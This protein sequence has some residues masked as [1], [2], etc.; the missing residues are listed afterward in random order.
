MTVTERDTGGAADVETEHGDATLG[1][2]DTDESI[3]WVLVNLGG[4]IEL[5]IYGDPQ[6]DLNHWT[7]GACSV[8]ID[9][10][11]PTEVG[12]DGLPCAKLQDYT[13]VKELLDALKVQHNVS[14]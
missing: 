2:Y 10:R 7:V 9:R 8:W 11:S 3:W 1:S 13:E 4:N 6:Q 14:G 12:F 5:E